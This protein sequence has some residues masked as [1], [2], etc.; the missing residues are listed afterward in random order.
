MYSITAHMLTYRLV[1]NER[2]GS[3]PGFPLYWATK[4]ATTLFTP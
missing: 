2:T 4:G 1:L 3:R